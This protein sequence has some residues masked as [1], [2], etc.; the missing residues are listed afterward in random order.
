MEK[1]LKLS[2]IFRWYKQDFTK[3]TQLIEYINQYT[4]IEINVAAEI[5]YL[6]YDWRLN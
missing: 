2:K 3:S 4:Y 5:D 1:Q 6:D